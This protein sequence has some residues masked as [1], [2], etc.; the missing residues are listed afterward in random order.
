MSEFHRT[1]VTIASYKQHH[2]S[3]PTQ[4]RLG[5]E[6]IGLLLEAE[7]EPGLRALAERMDVR[8]VPGRSISVGG[9]S[10]FDYEKGPHFNPDTAGEPNAEVYRWLGIKRR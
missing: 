2:G 10:V 3:W 5:S 9:L 7:G 1:V 6:S 4:L 8:V